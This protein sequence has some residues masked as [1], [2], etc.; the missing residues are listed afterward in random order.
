MPMWM[1]WMIWIVF[2]QVFFALLADAVSECK[3]YAKS[4][5]YP[6]L[7][8]GPIAVLI[9]L[10]RPDPEGQVYY[11]SD[12]AVPSAGPRLMRDPNTGMMVPSMISDSDRKLVFR[13]GHR[14]DVTKIMQIGAELAAIA[15][16]FR[17]ITFI[18][19]F[20][21]KET[22]GEGLHLLF[23]F[24]ALV[25]LFI[26]CMLCTEK[27]KALALGLLPFLL[28]FISHSVD[29]SRLID[30]EGR[31]TGFSYAWDVYGIY[32]VTAAVCVVLYFIMVLQTQKKPWVDTGA[33]TGPRQKK[34]KLPSKWASYAMAVVA[35]LMLLNRLIQG[36]VEISEYTN[37]KSANTGLTEWI[38]L[39]STLISC[40]FYMSYLCIAL[41]ELLAKDP[42]NTQEFRA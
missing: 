4:W 10:F 29:M 17:V 19:S 16:I 8:L 37:M 35:F 31:N 34:W 25:L 14:R 11:V 26:T 7:F 6:G 38:V 36:A 41:R 20:F 23:N 33:E 28:I 18:L 22:E 30:G 2:L 24:S 32:L 40:C 1:V 12:K 27:N 5:F 9:L 42:E 21:T 15:F 13:S 39:I 3:G